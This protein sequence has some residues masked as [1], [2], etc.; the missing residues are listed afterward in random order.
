VV[1]LYLDDCLIAKQVARQ[2]RAAGHLIYLTSELGTEGKSDALHLETATRLDAVLASQNTK[3]FVPLHHQW[4]AEGRR[5]AGILVT[6]HLAI[7]I[8][9]ERLERAARLLNPELAR[10]QLMQLHLFNSEERGQGYIASLT[11]LGP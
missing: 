8:R 2:L 11:P 7:G 9:I 3:D 4:Q 10:N 5:H 1:P 6:Q